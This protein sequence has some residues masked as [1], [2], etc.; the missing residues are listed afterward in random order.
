M[1]AVAAAERDDPSGKRRSDVRAH[2]HRRR[3]KERQDAR[4]HKPHDHNGGKSRILRDDR[5]RRTHANAG[6]PIPRRS[7]EQSFEFAMSKSR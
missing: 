5:Y 6:K 1:R 7:A 4:V 3:L 2:D